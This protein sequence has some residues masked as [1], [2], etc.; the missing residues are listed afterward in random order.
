M[1]IFF[2]G[3]KQKFN[4]NYLPF[5]SINSPFKV[6]T[7]EDKV[8]VQILLPEYLLSDNGHPR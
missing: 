3:L 5:F 7:C 6:L 8:I 2:I 1:L 4:L